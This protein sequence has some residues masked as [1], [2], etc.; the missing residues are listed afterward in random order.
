MT[1]ELPAYPKAIQM[2]GHSRGIHGTVN[3]SKEFVVPGTNIHTNSIECE[4]GLFK[5]GI[6]GSFHHVSGKH[7]HRYL[8]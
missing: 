1:D 7:L 3:H 8:T 2:A 5:R 4:F 6:I